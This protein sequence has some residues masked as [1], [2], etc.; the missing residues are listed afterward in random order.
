MMA[1]QT[2]TAG[3]VFALTCGA[4]LAETR[5]AQ[6]PVPATEVMNPVGTLFEVGQVA[7]APAI[8]AS[9]RPVARVEEDRRALLTMMST[10][11]SPRPVIDL[12]GL[13]QRSFRPLIRDFEAIQVGARRPR[14]DTGAGGIC[15]RSSIKGEVIAPVPG[16]G[17]CGI[18]NAVRVTAVSGLTLTRPARMDCGTAQALDTWVKDGVLP[19]IGRRG[20]GAVALQVAAGYACRT[21]NSQAGARVSEHGK[22]RAIDIS[23][24]LLANGSSIT[25]LRDWDRGAEGRMLRELH[26][27]ACGPFGTVLGPESDRFHRD[28]FHFDTAT[29]RSGSYC[30]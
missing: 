3:L 29:Y 15:G 24:I 18:P 6:R 16:N 4:A 1:R 14:Q 23:G 17:A 12:A 28:H 22:G 21:R 11:K 9:T 26:S 20:G 13:V 10:M 19:V 5:P 8:A 25:V 2:V 30:R 27:R 7:G